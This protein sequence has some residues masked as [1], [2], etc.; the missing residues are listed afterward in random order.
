MRNQ[1][2]WGQNYKTE[3]V[4]GRNTVRTKPSKHKGLRECVIRCGGVVVH[5]KRA[6]QCS[7]RDTRRP[8]VLGIPRVPTHMAHAQTPAYQFVK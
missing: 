1:G 7:I 4:V 5:V 2:D 6:A 8:P 3:V